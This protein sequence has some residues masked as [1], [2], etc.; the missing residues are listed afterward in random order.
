MK[1]NVSVIFSLIAAYTV[2]AME[3]AY[4]TSLCPPGT[5]SNLCNI[6]PQNTGGIVGTVVEVLLIIAIL[7]SLFFMIW[8]GIRYMSSGGD[9]GKLDQA[10]G[11]IV[12]AIIGLIISLLAFFILDF[13]LVFFTGQGVTALQLPTLLQ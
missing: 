2:L 4:A 13:L 12:G 8:G 5:F 11:T 3:P 6:K 9:K 10:R 7:S 1:K